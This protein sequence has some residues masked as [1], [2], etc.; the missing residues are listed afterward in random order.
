MW[1]ESFNTYYGKV[2]KA[3]MATKGE[4]MMYNGKYIDALYFSTSNGKLKIQYMY[5][6]IVPHI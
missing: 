4:V 6:T 1:G 2:K 3:V 5:G